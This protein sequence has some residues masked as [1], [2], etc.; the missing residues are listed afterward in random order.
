MNFKLGDKVKLKQLRI[1]IGT[2]VKVL[3]KDRP[4]KDKFGDVHYSTLKGEVKVVFEN[5][6]DTLAR[7]QIV[8]I[9]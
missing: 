7:S 4:I 3:D 9:D 5:Y 2:I 6:I 8:K 1:K